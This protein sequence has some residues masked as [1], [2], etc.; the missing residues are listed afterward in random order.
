MLAIVAVVA[1]LGACSKSGGG[2]SGNSST[3]TPS[4]S[5]WDSMAW[6]QGNWS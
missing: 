5:N 4:S 2:A 3:V 6:D 1:M